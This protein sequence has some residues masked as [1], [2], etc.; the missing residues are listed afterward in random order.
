MELKTRKDF[1]QLLQQNP[2]L[3]FIKLGAKW[4]KPC[5]IIADV[6]HD[7]F[8]KMPA[9]ILTFDLDVDVS[10]DL[11]AFLKTKKM[12]QGIPTILCYHTGNISYIPDDSVSG[13]DLNQIHDFFK[14]N[15]GS[16]IH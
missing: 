15:L 8:A 7:V 4:C 2:G 9:H 11:F 13:T 14:Q 12:V 5:A 10:S 6:V 3:I 16:V 1:M